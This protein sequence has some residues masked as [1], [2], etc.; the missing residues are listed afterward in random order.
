VKTAQQAAQAWKDSA[1]RAATNYTAGVN[2]YSGDWAG[3]TVSQEASLVTNFNQAVSSGRWRQ[4]VTNT[5]TGG[6]KSATQAK[7]PN[8]S[9]GFTAGADRQ[10][11]AI[12]KI[13]SAEQTL[14]GAL[15]P[16]GTYDQNKLRATAMMDGL[17]ALKGSLGA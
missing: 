1:G 12:Q 7:A 9:Q 15:P 10:A 5:G 17:H 11:A 8:Y 4:A 3:S 16:R 13:I 2:A 6:W 14:V